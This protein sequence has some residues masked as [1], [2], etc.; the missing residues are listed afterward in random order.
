MHIARP[1]LLSEH[2]VIDVILSKRG[3]RR[4]HNLC[5]LTLYISGIERDDPA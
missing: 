5:V 4:G 1:L 3:S 2:E